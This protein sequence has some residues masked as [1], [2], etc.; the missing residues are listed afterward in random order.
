MVVHSP[1]QFE[2]QCTAAAAAAAAAATANTDGAGAVPQ[3]T[4]VP[5]SVL[6]ASRA[7]ASAGAVRSAIE[8]V[9][10]EADL[11]G[12]DQDQGFGAW[13]GEVPSGRSIE[14]DVHATGEEI[15]SNITTRRVNNLSLI[16]I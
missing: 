1:N 2:V 12:G 8:D 16:H 5:P 13:T 10:E 3:P 4:A 9:A 14:A 7:A 6:A 15:N 11:L